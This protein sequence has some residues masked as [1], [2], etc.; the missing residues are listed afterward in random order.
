MLD[1]C[2]APKADV[3]MGLLSVPKGV[4]T[5]AAVTLLVAQ[6]S[7]ALT[8]ALSELPPAGAQVD[9]PLDTEVTLLSLKVIGPVVPLPT[10]MAAW[11]G[12]VMA[13]KAKMR[14]VFAAR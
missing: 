4:T 3:A 11:T 5:L 14:D 8:V 7:T 10:E 6:E 13:A 9:Q 2:A 12:M 1:H